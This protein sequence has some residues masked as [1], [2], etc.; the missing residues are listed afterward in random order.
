MTTGGGTVP[1]RRFEL[2]TRDPDLAHHTIADAYAEHRPRFAGSRQGFRF[3]LRTV[4]A[5]S[6]GL[7]RIVHSMDA[8]ART[9]PYPDFMTVHVLRGRFRF[10]DGDEELVAPAGAVARYPL[11]PSV[12][13]WT[14]VVGTMIRLP[15]EQVAHVATTRT[16]TTAAD[17][18]FLGLAPVS[19]ATSRAWTQLSA[20]LHGLGD[21]A[22]E[23][24]ILR[25]SLADLAAATALTV[26]PNTT[27][28][29]GYLPQPRRMTPAVV[30]RARA[31]L[32]EHAAEPVTVAEVAAACGVGARGLQAAFQRHDGR[33]PTAYLRR[34]RLE[35]AHRDLLAAEP[36]G[37]ETVAGIARRWGWTSPGRFAAAYRDAYG[38]PPRETLRG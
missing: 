17:F 30:R 26:F 37:G 2:V 4:Q 13:G 6:L 16:E 24:P 7:D 8:R 25:A 28:N 34:V 9:G 29:A 22:L 1:V 27:M 14:D 15:H 12:L 35:R 33:S 21:D 3:A 31:W 11:R 32:D 10:A 36:G 20:Y 23:Q 5:G 19:A 38:R 18:R